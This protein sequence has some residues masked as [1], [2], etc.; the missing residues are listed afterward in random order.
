M[1]LALIWDSH[2]EWLLSHS[3]QAGVLVLLVLLVQWLFRRQLTNR[4]RF[5]LWWIVLARLLL[6]FGPESAVSLFNIFR[7]AV[8][9]TT[10]QSSA[11]STSS[12]PSPQ[13]T[14]PT[15]A[16]ESSAVA[17][18]HS[19]T[20]ENEMPSID[21][22]ESQLTLANKSSAHSEATPTPIN[23]KPA[24][25]LT[26]WLVPGLTT[27]WLA[28][29]LGLFGVVAVQFVRFQGKLA[30][31]SR[32]AEAS[33]RDL[34][35]ECRREFGMKRVVE[36]LETDAVQSPALFGLWRLRLLLPPG[37]TT[38]FSRSELRYIFLHELAHVQ[39]GDLWLNWLVTGLQVLHW[40]NPLLWLG[41]ARLRADREL[42]CDELALLQAGDQ[43][44]TA[45]GETV[46]KLLENLNRPAA[47]PGLVGILEDKQQMR[48]RIVMIARFR[49]PG[50]WSVLAGLLVAGLAT[51]AL[52]DAQTDQ[53]HVRIKVEG[54][55]VATMAGAD[56]AAGNL[57][58]DN[59]PFIHHENFWLF[60]NGAFNYRE[61]LTEAQMKQATARIKVERDQMANAS[62]P[63]DTM[64]PYDP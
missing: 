25:R 45:Y 34:L 27:L 39:R 1:N 33:L 59:S 50:R 8:Q 18:P 36:L 7:P 30:T 35:E 3:L 44:G 49:R 29:V 38:Q 5:A 54:G 51:A 46:V 9:W 20:V 10:L 19:E 52:T 15:A 64:S 21:I 22:A 48:R 62:Q 56:E 42:A 28:G 4:W 37:L 61:P 40:F 47:I 60:R 26:D 58:I 53:T 14:Y 23:A 63:S 11:P 41:F 13:S 12:I 6:P 55:Q 32:P 17:I 2:P 43:A 16:P 57:Y 24:I 31:G